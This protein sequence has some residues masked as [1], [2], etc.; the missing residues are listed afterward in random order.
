MIFLL[1]TLAFP[2][3]GSNPIGVG[4][5]KSKFDC[6]G[7]QQEVS[8]NLGSPLTSHERK[9]A[10]SGRYTIVCL[11][12]SQI[13]SKLSLKFQQVYNIPQSGKRDRRQLLSYLSAGKHY[14]VNG[15]KRSQTASKLSLSR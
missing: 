9:K 13:A 4:T 7:R 14:I 10:R 6:G 12:R 8:L 3:V 2:R 5:F 15:S 1:T 11:R